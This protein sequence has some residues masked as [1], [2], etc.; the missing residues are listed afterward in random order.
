[1]LDIINPIVLCL[2]C[3][4]A[5]LGIIWLCKFTNKKMFLKLVTITGLRF[6]FTWVILT[7]VLLLAYIII[8]SS[9]IGYMLIDPGFI[10]SDT[11]SA[12]GYYWSETSGLEE[13]FF[14]QYELYKNL[15]DFSFIGF[16][17]IIFLI[18]LF[19][20]KKNYSKFKD[21]NIKKGSVFLT[22][23]LTI[24]LGIISLFITFLGLLG[25]I[26]SIENNF[27]MSQVG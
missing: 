26:L 12:G 6:F 13:A 17:I 7:N 20:K 16:L 2:L 15:I 1:M 27:I 18:S 3:G 19:F 8:H 5:S 25:V 9:F 11:G 23:L 24:L 4:I 22:V 21:E 10:E 14:D